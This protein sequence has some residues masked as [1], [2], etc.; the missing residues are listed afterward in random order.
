[1]SNKQQKKPGVKNFLY[2]HRATTAAGGLAALGIAL[3]LWKSTRA[4]NDRSW[5][6]EQDTLAVADIDGD[7]ATVRNVRCFDW[8]TATEPQ[9]RYATRSYDLRRLRSLDFI[10]S[11][12]GMR[13]LAGHT[14][15]SFGF[16]GGEQLAVSVEI[17]RTEGQHYSFLRGLF[18]NYELMYVIAD[19]R[20]IIRVRTNIRGEETYLY[21]INAPLDAIRRLL[22]SILRRAN[23]LAQQPEFYNSVWNSCT[24]NLLEH[25]N[26]A[27]ICRTFAH[28]PRAVVS[29]LADGLLYDL[30]LLGRG[31]SLRELRQRHYISK[32]AKACGDGPGFSAAIRRIEA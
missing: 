32:R 8:K 31:V 15:L 25:F 19:E 17:R 23:R 22:V 11:R 4:T 5:V 28:G 12:F 29:G 21:P 26:E 20:D 13:G 2:A 6:E 14:L 24:T 9:K 16:E 7:E 3:L 30:G 27:G 1:M 10:V 18:R